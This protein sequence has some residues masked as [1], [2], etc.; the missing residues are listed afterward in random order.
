MTNTSNILYKSRYSL[1]FPQRG[2]MTRHTQTYTKIQIWLYFRLQTDQQF[3]QFQAK[4]PSPGDLP[5]P[6]TESSS[7]ALQ[8]DSEPPG[9]P[10]NTGV[11]S[12]PF[13][14]GSFQP[15]NRTGVSCIAGRFFTIW[16]KVGQITEIYFQCYFCNLFCHFVQMASYFL[17]SQLMKLWIF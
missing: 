13:C 7:P 4:F 3:G 16:A 15:R 11:G 5:N 12:Y 8:A 10:K 9:K 17:C 1:T 14:N 6:G 2:T